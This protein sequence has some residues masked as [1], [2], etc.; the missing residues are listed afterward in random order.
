MPS[1]HKPS[2]RRQTIQWIGA[3]AACLMGSAMATTALAAPLW[4]TK[5]VTSNTGSS[6]NAPTDIALLSG[7]V[8]Y[9]ASAP[10]AV[11]LLIAQFSP[12]PQ[13]LWTHVGIVVQSSTTGQALWHVLHAMPDVGVALE[14]LASFT[15]SAQ[16]RELAVLR[17]QSPRLAQQLV[18]SAMAHLGKPFDNAM[19]WS[20]T[21]SL[22]CTQLLALAW[23]KHSAHSAGSSRIRVPMYSEPVLHPDSLWLD[24]LKSGDFKLLGS[25]MKGSTRV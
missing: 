11:S 17:P 12:L 19:R 1:P 8:I 20:D 13:S 7:D 10:D 3:A 4:A 25:T 18:H 9:R 22:Y 21:D 14:P 23:P 16:A 5:P 15:S 6:S 24:M 2:A